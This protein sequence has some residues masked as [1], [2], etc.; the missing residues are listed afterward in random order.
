[1]Q[2]YKKAY[3]FSQCVENRKP[4]HTGKLNMPMTQECILYCTMKGKSNVTSMSQI[5]SLEIDGIEGRNSRGRYTIIQK[6]YDQY[7]FDVEMHR[8]VGLLSEFD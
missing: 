7:S 6:R 4:I 5:G 2:S 3:E 8:N 1:M